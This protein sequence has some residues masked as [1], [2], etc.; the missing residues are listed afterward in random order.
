MVGDKLR[1]ERERQNLTIKDIEKGTSIRSLYIE[2][3]EAGKYDQLPGEVYTKGFIRNYANFLQL[4]ATALLHEYMEENH[5]DIA[6]Q[7]SALG[8][9]THVAP[10]EKPERAAVHFDATPM[11]SDLRQRVDHSHHRQNALVLVVLLAIIV[12]AGGVF[13]FFESASPDADQMRQVSQRTEQSKQTSPS[14]SSASQDKN[15]VAAKKEESAKK[16]SD[17]VEVT[18]KFTD[19]CWMEV[20]V[21]GKTV[22]EGMAEKG[23]TMNWKG[24]QHVVVTAGN[25]GAV[26]FTVNGKDMGKAGGMGEVVEKTFSADNN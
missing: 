5:P 6:A 7:D 11:T 16:A 1:A 25:A 13:F 3:I 12:I 9:P 2:N 14:P 19:R 20:K 22:F 15:R 10:A 21:D 4:D 26:Q 8:T 18:A 17:G 24:T 23:K